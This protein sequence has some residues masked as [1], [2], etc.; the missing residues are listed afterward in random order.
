MRK[1]EARMVNAVRDLLGNAAHAGTYYRLGN[2]EVGQSHHGV[3]G[4]FELS[5][6]YLR[7]FAWL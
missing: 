6:D 7:P 1:I 5:A 3:H 2:T 4:T